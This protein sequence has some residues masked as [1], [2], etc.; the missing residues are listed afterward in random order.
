[1]RLSKTMVARSGTMLARWPLLAAAFFMVAAAQ[2]AAPSPQATGEQS[3]PALLR[4]AFTPIR[5]LTKSGSPFD[6][7]GVSEKRPQPQ[8]GQK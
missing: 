8:V 5:G 2:A 3:C 1:M 4:H 6:Q 7:S